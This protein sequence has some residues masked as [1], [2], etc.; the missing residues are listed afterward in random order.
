MILLVMLVVRLWWISG[1]GA[2]KG[3]RA[4]RQVARV[5]R[6][7]GR[8]SVVLNDLLLPSSGDRT[9]QVDHVLV[10]ERGIFV[11]ETK[12]LAGYISGSRHSQYWHQQHADGSI[13]SFYNP[14]LQNESHIRAV[15]RVLPA[16]Q[17]GCFI[18]VIVF[19]DAREIDVASG[20]YSEWIVTDKDHLLSEIMH[21]DRILSRDQI[22]EA[23]NA[24]R[25][26]NITSASARRQ[27]VSFVKARAQEVTRSISHGVCPRC[28]APLRRR[29]S[30]A[31]EFWGCSRFPDCRFTCE[32]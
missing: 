6:G 9:S 28:G 29:S 27:H 2:R 1:E 14:L 4:E 16:W 7:A 31:G 24:L 32:I 5:L 18:S 8:K 21:H 22:R 13:T 17:A 19:T 15:R 3:R 20:Y 12:S 30:Q 23:A 25:R 10:S 26:A 11:I